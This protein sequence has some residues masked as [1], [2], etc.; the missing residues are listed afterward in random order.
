MRRWRRTFTG[1]ATAAAL[2]LLLAACGSS[3]SES[4]NE[5]PD[6]SS[7]SSKKSAL[8]SAS[9]A[10][11][12]DFI[13][14]SAGDVSLKLGLS[15]PRSGS[16]SAYAPFMQRGA[17]LAVKQLEEAGGIK[18][19]IV[20]KDHKSG[21]PQAGAA[22]IRELGS[23]KVHQALTS[24]V[25]ALGAQLPAIEQFKI[26]TI[27][28][29]GGIGT[30]S[31]SPFFYGTRAVIPA[32]TLKGM[33]AWLEEAKPQA[34][35][36]AH[37][38]WDVG[39]PADVILKETTSAIEGAGF[40]AG[41]ALKSAPGENDYSS[42]IT[43]LEAGKPDVILLSVLDGLDIS[44]FLRQYRTQ[45]GNAIVVG[46]ANYDAASFDQ[47]ADES[48]KENFYFTYDFFDAGNVKSDFAKYF[49]E[50]YEEQY[51]EAPNELAANFYEATLVQYELA[52]RVIADGGDP[53]DSEQLVAA[54]DGD[55]S[56]IS[57]YGGEG[58]ETGKLVFDTKSHSVSLRNAG[59]FRTGA[60]GTIDVVATFDISG[61][62]FTIVGDGE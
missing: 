51:G 43:N 22:G 57:L 46:T 60:D 14:I 56:F 49:V 55:P 21:D 4:S 7:S 12:G 50:T 9:G 58:K 30:F 15:L 52:R 37:V 38:T 53:K 29:A 59:I 62:G 5:G 44:K 35:K 16:G 31:E 8:T 10:E 19:D 34:K 25:A 40:E 6:D 45:G 27:D 13:E 41:P 42:I 18:F 2:A 3:G 1:I 36:I 28:P 20:T 26:L 61:D 23:E 24:Y 33:F 32:D 17:E 47:V 48:A 11:L 54:L 39:P